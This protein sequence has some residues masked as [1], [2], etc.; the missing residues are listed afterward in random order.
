MYYERHN[1]A[2]NKYIGL[3]GYCTLVKCE[4][5]IFQPAPGNSCPIKLLE[6]NYKLSALFRRAG[7][8]DERALTEEFQQDPD[9][10][11]LTVK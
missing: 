3:L 9:K 6:E 11:Q 10:N 2:I 4:K 5:C 1:E 8:L 7:E